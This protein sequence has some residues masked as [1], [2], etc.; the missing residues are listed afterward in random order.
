M[1]R[2][3]Q[4]PDFPEPTWRDVIVWLAWLG[5]LVALMSAIMAMGGCAPQPTPQPIGQ[6]T[7]LA[8]R[9]VQLDP[10][11]AAYDELRALAECGGVIGVPTVPMWMEYDSPATPALSR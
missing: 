8:Q 11:L 10:E 4:E 5:G 6:P 1:S 2:S 9:A 7:P 3:N